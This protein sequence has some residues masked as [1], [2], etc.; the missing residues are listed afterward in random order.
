MVKKW[1][2]LEKGPGDIPDY[3]LSKDY[4]SDWFIKLKQKDGYWKFQI[5]TRV[6]EGEEQKFFSYTGKGWKSLQTTKGKSLE[7]LQ[8][9]KKTLKI[10]IKPEDN[11]K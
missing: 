4:D 2:K 7:Y 10:P 11:K 1:Q 5:G 9:I 8:T 3:I 6:K